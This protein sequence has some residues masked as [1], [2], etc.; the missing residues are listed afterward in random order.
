M[1]LYLDTSAILKRYFQESFSEEVSAKWKQSEMI[2]TSSVAYAETMATISRKQKEADIDNKVIQK[3]IQAFQMDW[4]GFIRVEVTDDLNEY[5]NNVLQKH[6]LR[7]FDA[8]HLASALV[9]YEKF[10]RTFFFA[11]FDQ[12]LNQAARLESLP[13]F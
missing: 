10:P 11:C 4:S 9:I 3:T 8:I 5:I 13:S 12:R 6:P 2:V 7:G 1:I